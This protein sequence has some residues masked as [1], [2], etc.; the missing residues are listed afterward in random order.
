MTE[1]LYKANSIRTRSGRYVNLLDPDPE[2]LDLGDIAYA[3]AH[4]PRFGGHLQYQWSV[5]HHSLLVASM[6]PQEHKL[7]A[8]LHDA[9]E[10]FLCD[11]PS[12]LK[13]L[14]PEYKHIEERMM[15]AIA[16]RFGMPWPLAAEVKVVDKLALEMEWHYLMLGIRDG[17]PD[18]DRITFKQTL[19]PF[20]ACELLR[21]QVEK[22]IREL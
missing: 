15:Q 6:V 14:L 21:L 1:E 7:Q 18:Q 4:V 17:S 22:A 5:A 9:S 11:L 12:P 8:L 13:A 3:L 16:T 10:A 2:T 20:A 19:G